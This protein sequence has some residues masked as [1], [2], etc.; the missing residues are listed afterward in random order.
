MINPL[1]IDLH[2]S[3]NRFWLMFESTYTSALAEQVRSPADPFAN[4]CA[5]PSLPFLPMNPFR[6]LLHFAQT[7]VANTRL[8]TD[9]NP[10]YNPLYNAHRKR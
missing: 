9:S 10:L 1:P 3:A 2:P 7:L 8:T 4:F 5:G 6:S